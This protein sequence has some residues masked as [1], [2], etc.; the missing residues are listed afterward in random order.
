M[1]QQA[2]VRI[3]K[4]IFVQVVSIQKKAYNAKY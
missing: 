2:A 1:T 4:K 3:Y